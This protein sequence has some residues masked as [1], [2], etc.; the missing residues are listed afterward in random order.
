MLR[1]RRSCGVCDTERDAFC[2]RLKQFCSGE[3]TGCLAGDSCGEMCVTALAG[4][5]KAGEGETLAFSSAEAIILTTLTFP[6]VVSGPSLIL[7]IVYLSSRGSLSTSS[8]QLA[9]RTQF[10]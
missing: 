5:R 10:N 2:S 8:I 1:A 6:D 3:I 7:A 4:N 9:H